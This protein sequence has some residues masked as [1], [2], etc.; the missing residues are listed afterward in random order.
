[1]GEI[2]QQITNNQLKVID[3]QGE[4]KAMFS[5]DSIMKKVPTKTNSKSF[6]PIFVIHPNGDV[7]AAYAAENDR[8]YFFVLNRNW[9]FDYIELA[10]SGA[11]SE[12][13][14]TISSILAQF[15][16]QEIRILKNCLFALKGYQFKNSDIR[17]Y[18]NGY[19]WYIPN[20]SE[21]NDISGL[22]TNQKKL[23]NLIIEEEANR[24]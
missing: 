1:V 4:E 6:G 13:S 24:K 10:R 20:P 7:Y 21:T 17:S 14:E 22:T 9:G 3:Q 15:N 16:N 8:I 2:Y 11:T 18:F 19:N 12:N 23:L 5:T